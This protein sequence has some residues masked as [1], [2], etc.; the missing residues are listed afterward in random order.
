VCVLVQH[1]IGQTVE[2][3]EPEPVDH[4]PR[5]VQRAL[6]GECRLDLLCAHDGLSK[7]IHAELLGHSLNVE[8]VHVSSFSGVFRCFVTLTLRERAP[9]CQPQGS[10]RVVNRCSQVGQ[11]LVNPLV[12]PVLPPHL[13]QEPE[14]DG[15]HGQAVHSA[16]TEQHNQKDLHFL[17]PSVQHGNSALSAEYLP[18]RLIHLSTL[19]SSH[20]ALLDAPRLP[21]AV[22]GGR[23]GPF[24]PVT[25][26]R[27]VVLAPEG[28]APEPPSVRESRL[29][30]GLSALVPPL[31]C[32][33]APPP[34]N[35]NSD[36]YT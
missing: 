30:H 27:A 28:H 26:P 1:L 31:S 18:I 4:V 7:L 10:R 35:Q 33:G 24:A 15:S 13:V 5:L 22:E 23:V 21:P 20:L 32:H 8:P 16:R 14:R 3:V 36:S 19:F 25:P 17:P 9:G 29:P 6:P 2:A 12:L 34:R 11:V